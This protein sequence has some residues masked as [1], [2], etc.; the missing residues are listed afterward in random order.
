[1]AAVADGNYSRRSSVDY[2]DSMRIAFAAALPLGSALYLSD[3]NILDNSSAP[4]DL[5]PFYNWPDYQDPRV[6]SPPFD[7]PGYT[8]MSAAETYE[9]VLANAGARPADRD[10]VDERIVNEVI[11]RTGSQISTED[12][13]GGYPPLAVNSRSLEL[14]ADPHGDADGNGYTNL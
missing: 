5:I 9:F 14:P 7:L 6:A 12:E 3:D 2:S 13:V 4:P 10:A 1:P 11:N 8:P